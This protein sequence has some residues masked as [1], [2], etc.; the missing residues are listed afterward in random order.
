MSLGC[1]DGEQRGLPAST[2]PG[3]VQTSPKSFLE[4]LTAA[5]KEWMRWAG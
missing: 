4:S 1:M 2:Q 5:G 3:V